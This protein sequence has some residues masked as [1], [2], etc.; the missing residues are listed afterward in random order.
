MMPL[1][2]SARF[3]TV[4]FFLAALSLPAAKADP[5]SGLPVWDKAADGLE[6]GLL[7]TTPGLPANRRV[8]LNSRVDYKVLAR[9]ASNQE[10]VFEVHAHSDPYL[11]P[12]GSM[13]DAFRARVLPER[14][15]ALGVTDLSSMVG[16]YDVKLSPGEA[17]VVPGE[18][19]VYV[20]AADPQSFP[21]VETVETGKNWIIQPIR[22]HG[23]NAAER[24]QY[25]KTSATPYA[26]KRTVT[27]LSRDG[28][29]REVSV[30]LVG[31]HTDGKLL[32]AKIQIE[33][34][35]RK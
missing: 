22:I 29:A 26:E 20:G 5:P 8:F 28:K 4:L 32:F 9:N 6:P 15:R 31:A 19:G 27:I 11:V 3:L 14:F 17:V 33:V 10:R 2:T 23:L 1:L 21:R 18:R 12:D 25:V 30:P 7:L 13:R 16:A 34:E 35:T 24:A